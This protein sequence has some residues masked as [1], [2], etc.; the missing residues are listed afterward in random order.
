MIISV[1]FDLPEVLVLGVLEWL[2][3]NDR[4][5]LD[6][7]SCTSVFR[8]QLLQH[9]TASFWDYGL[10]CSSNDVARVNWIVRKGGKLLRICILLTTTNLTFDQLHNL[11][12]L[13]TAE[14]VIHLS[15]FHKRLFGNIIRFIDRITVAKKLTLFLSEYSLDVINA[16]L[17][18]SHVTERCI[19]CEEFSS[20]DACRIFFDPRLHPFLERVSGHSGLSDSDLQEAEQIYSNTI[21]LPSVHITKLTELRWL[22]TEDIEPWVSDVLRRSPSLKQLALWGND[23][24]AAIQSPLLSNLEEYHAVDLRPQRAFLLPSNFVEQLSQNSSFRFSLRTLSLQYLIESYPSRHL[25]CLIHLVN[26]EQLTLD[27]IDCEEEDLDFVLQHMPKLE[28]LMINAV[29]GLTYSFYG[30]LLADYDCKELILLF[31]MENWSVDEI[32]TLFPSDCLGTAKKHQQKLELSLISTEE[33][34]E[35]VSVVV[36]HLVEM[37]ACGRFA[38]LQELTVNQQ[39]LSLLHFIAIQAG[40]PILE[41]LYLDRQD[42]S[43]ELVL[44]SFPQHWQKLKM[45]SILHSYTSRSGLLAMASSSRLLTSINIRKWMGVEDGGGGVVQQW[46][47]LK[48]DLAKRYPRIRIK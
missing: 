47:E 41:Q 29:Y 5:G 33:P 17:H 28:R 38:N 15:V 22:G 10:V 42:Q 13:Y 2:E 43:D 48:Q 12:L 3:T 1:L 44:R 34:V 21:L 36:D 27:N 25:R 45:L 9:F 24:L 30:R 31:R 11:S 20:S 19:Q 18:N 26:L 40:C 4:K 35:V 39:P 7:A 32:L 6:S 8:P 16:F 46:S 37:I 14:S 23:N